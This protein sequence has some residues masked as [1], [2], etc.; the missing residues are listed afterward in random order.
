MSFSPP[1]LIC[2]ASGRFLKHCLKIRLSGALQHRYD[3][4][5]ASTVTE[6]SL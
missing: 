5:G 4:K 2:L 3:Q 6:S 1:C